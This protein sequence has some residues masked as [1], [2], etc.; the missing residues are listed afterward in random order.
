M[1]AIVTTNNI[2][3]RDNRA[4]AP[5]VKDDGSNYPW[6]MFFDNNQRIVDADTT[7]E[8]LSFLIP[9][10]DVMDETARYDARVSL[11]S[12]V[13]LL[14]RATVLANLTPEQA[15][16]IKDWEWDVLTYSEETG[17]GTADPYGWGDGTQPIGTDNPDVVDEWSSEVPLILLDIN[18]HP[19]TDI[20]RPVSSEG[21][22]AE[23]KNIIW[24]RPNSEL[25][26]LTS[27]SRIGY[28]TFGTP[29]A[30]YQEKL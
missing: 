16:T 4:P 15:E 2:H 13:R 12:Q 28:I 30:V 5:E 23:V 14:A 7:D 25:Q 3:S 1:V 19:Y 9:N 6:R 29:A 20:Y 10:Y 18:Y 24:L 8:L 27:L 26:L 17:D 22:Y 11:A 21:D